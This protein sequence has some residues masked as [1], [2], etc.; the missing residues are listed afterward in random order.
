MGTTKIHQNLVFLHG[1][2]TTWES[3]YPLVNSLKESYNVYHPNLPYPQDK[4]LNLD[5]YCQFVIDFLKKEK[6]KNPILVGHSLGGAIS[7]KI[8][9]DHPNKIK[10]IILLSA[11]AIRHELPNHIK[12]FQKFSKPLHFFRQPILKILKLD[13]SDYIALKTDIEKQTFRNL[14]HHDLTP[15]LH[16]IT[17][18]TL[19]LWG[20]EDTSTPITDGQKIHSLIKNSIFKSFPKTGHFFYLTHSQ[21]VVDL[22]SN[23]AIL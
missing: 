9:I 18:P 11:A 13:A 21:E 4:V 1:W 15:Q 3:L 16:Q 12:L 19:I 17:I 5:D 6:I 14:I 20:D 8:A 22:I 7:C 23:F 10:K 2:G